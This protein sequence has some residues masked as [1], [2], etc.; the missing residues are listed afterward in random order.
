MFE[1]RQFADLAVG[2]ST[3]RQR[4][5]ALLMAEPGTR[6]HLR[7]IQ[8]RAS[9]SPGTA[10]RELTKL[11]SAGLIEREAEGNQVYFR[12]STSPFATMLRSLLVTAP[13]LLPGSTAS[14]AA[15]IGP[16]L[17]SRVGATLPAPDGAAAPAPATPDAVAGAAAGVTIAPR[18]VRPG[19]AAPPSGPVTIAGGIQPGTKAD[20]L[21]LE[22]GATVAA[23]MRVIYRERLR[24]VYLYGQRASGVAPPDSDVDLLV[25][26]DRIERYGEELDRTGTVCASLSLLL[27][28]VVS[29]IFVSETDWR[30]RTDG[31][32]PG[33]RAEAVSL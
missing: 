4:I 11:V 21:G 9:T 19:I 28:V 17:A 30:E 15:G 18:V 8:R 22:A 10:S 23:Q 6:L 12:A 25:V 33:V 24:G 5:L 27:G 1:N 7:A 13:T 16:S 20:P 31:Q 2:R 29:R 14:S 3:V 32:L 26:L